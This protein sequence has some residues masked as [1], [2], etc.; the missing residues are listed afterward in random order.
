MY[1]I[2]VKDFN[3]N[4][5]NKYKLSSEKGKIERIKNAEKEKEEKVT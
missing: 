1:F 2:I 4:S 3:Y 5:K